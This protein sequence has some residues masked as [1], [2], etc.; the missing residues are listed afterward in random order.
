[1]LPFAATWIDLEALLLKEVSQR[2]RQILFVSTNMW[3]LKNYNQLVNITKRSRL[4]DT[5]SKLEVTCGEGEAGR[6]IKGWRSKRYKVLGI[7]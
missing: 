1:M 3:N 6:T 5:E 7:K 4:T 2:E